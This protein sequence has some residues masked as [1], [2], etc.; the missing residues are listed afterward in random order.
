MLQ[1][2]QQLAHCMAHSITNLQHINTYISRIF[3]EEIKSG[4]M[5]Q[6][7]RQEVPLTLPSNKQCAS[8]SSFAFQVRCIAQHT[9]TAT[10]VLV[11]N[12]T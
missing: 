1:M 7:P 5:T 6:V 12:N 2:W 3:H 8:I 11:C 9:G 10:F 4:V